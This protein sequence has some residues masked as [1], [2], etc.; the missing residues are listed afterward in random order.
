MKELTRS[1]CGSVR[2]DIAGKQSPLLFLEEVGVI[3]AVLD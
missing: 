3:L 1:F 2:R